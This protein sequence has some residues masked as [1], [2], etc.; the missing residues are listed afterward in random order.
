VGIELVQ[1][2]TFIDELLKSKNEI[3][4]LE[5]GCGSASRIHFKPKSHMVGIDISPKQL[6]RNTILD[7]KILGDIQSY[8][9]QPS[10]FDV[11]VCW[12]VLEHLEKP[13]AALEK[14]AYAVKEGGIVILKLPNLISVKGLLTKFTPHWFHVLFYKYIYGD[15]KAREEDRGPFKTYMRFSISPQSLKKTAAYSGL[16]VVYID[17]FS[18]DYRQRNKMLNYLFQ[19]AYKLAHLASF[20][21]LGD[22]EVI[23]VWQK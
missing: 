17:S 18:A 11:I 2:Q 19:A 16:R 9:F 21:K 1:L 15:K 14:F 7:E 13:Q 8:D 23:M 6:F 5:A 3:N 12:D 4:V 20:R 10:V 22:S